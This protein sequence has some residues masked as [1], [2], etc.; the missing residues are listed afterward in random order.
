M[1][2]F[3][4][5]IGTDSGK[6]IVSA[7]VTEALQADYWKPIQAGKEERDCEKVDRLLTNDYSIVHEEQFLLNTPASPHFAA[8]VDG[9]EINVGDLILPETTNNLVIE[10]AGG[11]LVPINNKG[12]FIIDIATKFDCEIILV[13]NLYL[14]S[15]NH[16]IL[17]INELKAR[18]AKVKGIVFNGMRN[19]SS[20]DYILNYSGYKCL[21]KI[22][23]HDTFNQELLRK[24]AIDLM[25]NFRDE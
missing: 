21:L 14:G 15:I 23:R 20:E 17:T 4:T 24:Y 18:K 9:V 8:E 12:E 22:D 6:T 13:A 11:V 1:N 19:P 10:G 3:I 25:Y 5:A 7:I 16:T 2:Y